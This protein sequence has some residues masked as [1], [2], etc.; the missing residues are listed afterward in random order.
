MPNLTVAEEAITNY[1]AFGIHRF[2][3]SKTDAEC[4]VEADR[5]LREYR[6]LLLAAHDAE[7]VEPFVRF[8]LWV[9]EHQRE[10]QADL[11]GGDIQD[12]M[13]AFG[14]LAPTRVTEACSESC[15]CA[16]FD[17][18]MECYRDSDLTKRA[19]DALNRADQRRKETP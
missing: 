12:K 13:V 19:K 2:R 6:D 3:P 10:Y 8:T 16:E 15:V 11:N 14:I 18:P 7:A 5:L 1:L 4:E 9:L 17:F